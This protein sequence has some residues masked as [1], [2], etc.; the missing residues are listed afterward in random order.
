MTIQ[1]GQRAV[2]NVTLRPAAP[3]G[4]TLRVIAN[5]QGARISI[6]GEPAGEAPAT[7]TNL[8]PGEHNGDQHSPMT[9]PMAKLRPLLDEAL[10]LLDEGFAVP[11]AELA[12]MTPNAQLLR[13]LHMRYP[14]F[15]NVA[16]A[17]W[18]IMLQSPFFIQAAPAYWS[19]PVVYRHF[20]GQPPPKSFYDDIAAFCSAQPCGFPRFGGEAKL[21]ASNVVA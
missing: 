3:Q 20:V 4:G 17:G 10:R 13:F 21:P 15:A 12:N 9:I 14:E 18:R 6:D 1:T 8:A 7:R 11:T 5:A 2:L 19:A 16:W